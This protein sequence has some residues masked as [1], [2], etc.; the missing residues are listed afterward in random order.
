MGRPLKPSG[1]K[2]RD[3]LAIMDVDLALASRKALR[4]IRTASAGITITDPIEWPAIM[5]QHMTLMSEVIQHIEDARLERREV[6]SIID[7]WA[8]LNNGD[9][10]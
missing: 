7:K 6:V 9:A 10:P 8:E 3:H 1:R 4:Q 2:A 5:R